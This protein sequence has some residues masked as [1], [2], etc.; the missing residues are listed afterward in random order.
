LINKANKGQ[1]Q[2]NVELD[3]EKPSKLA[4]KREKNETKT[5][6]QGQPQNVYG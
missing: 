1:T 4:G 6:K 5:S 3:F 2:L